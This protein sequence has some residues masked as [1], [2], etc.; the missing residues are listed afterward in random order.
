MRSM[1]VA[2]LQREL[3]RAEERLVLPAVHV[4]VRGHARREPLGDLEEPV[5]VV[6]EELGARPRRTFC[7]SLTTYDQSIASSNRRPARE[8]PRRSTRIFCLLSPC[9]L[10][11][12]ARRGPVDRLHP[13]SNSS[14]ARRLVMR[15]KVSSS[16]W[17]GVDGVPVRLRREEG[18]GELDPQVSVSGELFWSQFAPRPRCRRR[19]R[20]RGA[21]RSRSRPPAAYACRRAGRGAR[22]VGRGRI[23]SAAGR[24]S[25]GARRPCRRRRRGRGARPWRAVQQRR[26]RSSRTPSR[27]GT[28]SGWAAIAACYSFAARRTCRHATDAKLRP[29]VCTSRRAP[30]ALVLA[31]VSP[32]APTTRRDRVSDEI[33][34]CTPRSHH[35]RRAHEDRALGYAFRAYECSAHAFRVFDGYKCHCNCS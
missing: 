7:E 5:A 6:R 12:R 10:R 16:S 27:D 26:R 11:S 4:R 9:A 22:D 23:S 18:S 2:E 20:R 24:R 33:H 13:P 29:Y 8:L 28:R 1:V 32:P 14:R 15:R 17:A 34:R 30:L 25:R 35:A 19:G 31:A 21:R 3:A